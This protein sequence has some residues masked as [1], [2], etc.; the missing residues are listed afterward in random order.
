MSVVCV[1][2]IREMDTAAETGWCLSLPP[3]SLYIINSSQLCVCVLCV[4][5][6]QQ[7]QQQLLKGEKE[8]K[9]VATFSLLG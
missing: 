5:Q 8:R 6:Q 4:H 9:K 3:T 7:Q 1:Q 2:Y